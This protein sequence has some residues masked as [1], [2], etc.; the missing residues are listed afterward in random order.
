[1]TIFPP[2]VRIWPRVSG[3][4]SRRVYVNQEFWIK[5][6]R[7]PSAHT[8]AGVRAIPAA[9]TSALPISIGGQGRAGPLLPW[10]GRVVGAYPM[11]SLHSVSKWRCSRVDWL[12]CT[13][14]ECATFLQPPRVAAEASQDADSTESP[15]LQ[16]FFPRHP[17]LPRLGNRGD[18]FTGSALFHPRE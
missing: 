7:E 1:M 3:R 18:C 14:P 12:P 15:A 17:D 11:E 6:G 10:S 8:N 5:R 13:H 9:P 16:V 2:S 4:S